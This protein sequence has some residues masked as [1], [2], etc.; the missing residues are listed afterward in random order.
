MN[1]D[2]I[3][4][5]CKVLFEANYIKSLSRLERKIFIQLIE[6]EF[7]TISRIRIA[8]VIDREAKNIGEPIQRR[9][10]FSRMQSSLA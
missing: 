8:S 1:W 5:K 2:N 9:S 4:K 3:E 7:P 10:F 6:E